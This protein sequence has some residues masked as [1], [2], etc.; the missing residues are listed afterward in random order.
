MSKRG[1]DNQI[2]RDSYDVDN[3]GGD[4]DDAGEKPFARASAAVI[5]KREIKAPKSRLR[6]AGASSAGFGASDA[7][8][9]TGNGM[10]GRAIPR[11]KR[12]KTSIF[13]TLLL[14]RSRALCFGESC[15]V[16]RVDYF[17]TCLDRTL[18]QMHSS[19][20]RLLD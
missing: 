5:A 19:Q 7:G 12:G 3:D 6:G 9:G 20:G 13:L 14:S 1:A 10:V 16:K 15:L 2:D 11:R 8:T 17:F 4:S 18:L